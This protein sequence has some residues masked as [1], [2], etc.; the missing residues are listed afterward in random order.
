MRGRERGSGKNAPREQQKVSYP[1]TA[2]SPTV[3]KNKK[4][5]NKL[6]VFQWVFKDNLMPLFLLQMVLLNTI[7]R[8]FVQATH[9]KIQSVPLNN[10]FVLSCMGPTKDAVR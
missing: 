8:L 1:N 10:H 7:T 5:K 3:Q 2:L 4:K 6:Y 9:N